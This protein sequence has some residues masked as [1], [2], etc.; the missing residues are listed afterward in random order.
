MCSSD[1][2]NAKGS[3]TAVLQVLICITLFLVFLQVQKAPGAMLAQ[4]NPLRKSEN[5]DSGPGDPKVRPGEKPESKQKQATKTAGEL[6]MLHYVCT[7]YLTCYTLCHILQN[8]IK[9]VPEGMVQPSSPLKPIHWTCCIYHLDKLLE[10]KEWDHMGLYTTLKVFP[11][12][13]NEQHT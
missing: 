5:Q 4:P 2:S 12:E 11:E 6:S 1:Y 3:W 13:K 8:Q 7:D 10:S 9:P